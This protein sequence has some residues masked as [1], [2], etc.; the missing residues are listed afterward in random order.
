[1]VREARRGLAALSFWT[2]LMVGAVVSGCGSASVEQAAS[3]PTE[4][5]RSPRVAPP[6]PSHALCDPGQCS[7]LCARLSCVFGEGA[8]ASAVERCLA[9]CADRCGDAYFE[10]A[11]AVLMSCVL[12]GDGAG[13]SPSCAKE[14]ACCDQHFTTELCAGP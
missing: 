6:P 3:T 2:L 13:P 7:A 8:G 1:M 14:R 4:R 11:D 10:R 5:L 9:T 12:G